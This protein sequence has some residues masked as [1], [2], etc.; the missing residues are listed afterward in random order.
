MQLSLFGR[1]EPAFDGSFASATRVELP[2]G[3][4]LEHQPGWLSG[5]DALYLELADTV[6]WKSERRV[7]YDREVDVPRLTAWFEPG[8]APALLQRMAAALG[9]RHAVELD[10]ISAA[11]YRD[12]SD[13]VAWHRDQIGR[14]RPESIVAIVSLGEPR[15]FLVRP[16]Q[17]GA[18]RAWSVGR[19][20][21]MVLGG[22]IQSLYDHSVPKARGAGPRI[23]LMFRHA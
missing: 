7:M 17:G 5:S 15:R 14:D 21:L 20:D 1:A 16:H 3:A 10:H 12:G 23:S 13:S 18:S 11:W 22:T 19:G 9:A 8:T 6:D 4:W 2:G